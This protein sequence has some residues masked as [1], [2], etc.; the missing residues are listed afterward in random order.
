MAGQYTFLLTNSKPEGRYFFI[1][2]KQLHFSGKLY[3]YL[4]VVLGYLTYL[5]CPRLVANQLVIIKVCSTCFK[6]S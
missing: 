6:L 5:P 4:V 1:G 3:K 2:T